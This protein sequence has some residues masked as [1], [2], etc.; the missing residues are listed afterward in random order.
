MK[1]ETSELLSVP[2]FR[3]LLTAR[4]ISNFGNGL[5]PVAIAFGVLSLPGA[6]A[7]SLSL[8]MFSQMLP[9]VVFMLIGGVIADRFPRAMLMGVTDILLSFLVIGNGIALATHHATL[10]TMMIVGLLSGTLNAIWWPAMSGLVPDLVDDEHLQ[11]ANSFVA[12]VCNFANIIGAVTA[13]I[14]VAAIGS[15]PA[16]VIDGITF[17]IAGSLVFTLRDF[18]KRREVNEHSPSVI[19]DLVHG[20]R[21]FT[22]LKWV[23]TI[24]AGYSIIVMLFESA[25]TVVGPVLAKQSLGGAKPWSWILASLSIGMVV[26]VTTTVR[27]RPKYPLFIGLVV[28]AGMVAWLLAMGR[29]TSI[30]LAMICAFLCGFAMDFF[31]VLWQTAL[32]AKVPRDSLSRVASYDAFGS[33]FF[34]PLGLVISGPIVARIGTRTTFTAYAV[35]TAIVIIAMLSVKEVR[36]LKNSTA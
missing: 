28:Q 13:G 36:Q 3:T 9:I 32:Q 35:V 14:I 16:I 25:L 33:L 2:A 27:V 20:W 5:S 1:Q 34:T 19:D 18:G 11:A 21:E 30:A 23:V 10:H 4:T 8:V 15:G 26:G 6:T 12:L 22:A 17:F 24:V 31:M 29:S 7:K